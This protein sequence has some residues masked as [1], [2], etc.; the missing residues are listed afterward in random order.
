MERSGG[1]GLDGDRLGGPAAAKRQAEPVDPVAEHGQQGRQ[2]DQGADR[3]Q[4]DDGDAGVAEGAQEV[5]REHQQGEQGDGDGGGREQDRAAGGAHGLDQ[6]VGRLAPGAQLFPVAGDDEQAVVD[7]Q[8]EAE[9]GGQVE[10]VDG[11]VGELGQH[12]QDQQGADDGEAADGQGQGAGHG[13]AEHH[14]QQQQGDGDG[15]GLGLGQVGLDLLADLTGD[16]GLA[17]DLDPE[18]GVVAPVGGGELLGP[19]VQP[20]LV[21]G[22]PAKD[23]RLAAVLAPEGR[24]VQR[25]VGGDLGQVGLGSQPPGERLPRRGHRRVVDGPPLGGDQ[26][27]QVGVADAEVVA[28]GLGGSGRLRGRVIE[29]ARLEP[30]DGAAAERARQHHRDQRGREHR[31][32]A[33]YQEL[34]EPFEHHDLLSPI[35]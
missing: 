11:D 16:L 7:G 23:E 30:G 22:D 6:G 13:A 32:A 33:P 20:F 1:P 15:D 35:S 28:Q 17:A 14:H 25:P 8:A 21:A 4:G 34:A 12:P 18:I 9:R 29:P 10:G 2:H 24:G 27:D 3:G 26:Q 31:P 5:E 19:L